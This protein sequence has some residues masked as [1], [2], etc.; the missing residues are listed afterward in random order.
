MMLR[1][2]NRWLAG[3]AVLSLCTLSLAPSTIRAADTKK[4]DVKWET[5]SDKVPENLEEL[6]ALQDRVKKVVDK[7]S[8][9][10]VGILIGFGAGSAVIVSEDGLVLTAAHVVT[11]E[12]PNGKTTPY[13]P[14]KECRIVLSDGKRVKAKSLGV[15]SDTDCGMV[16]ITEKNPKEGSDGKWPFLPIGKSADVKKGQ[17]VVS[18]G[19]PGGPKPGR[20]P[21]AR[22]GRVEGSTKE[23]LRSNCT[24]VGGDS[25]GPLFDLDGNVIGIHS[26]IGLTL[27]HN[28]HI[29][30]EAFKAQWDKLYSSKVFGKVKRPAPLVGLVFS[31][32]DGDDA[33]VADVPDDSPAGKAG[34]KAG[35]TITKVD[36]RSIKS[37]E[38]F[39]EAIQDH[40]PG[41]NVK[42]TVRR[43]TEVL[44]L[45]VTLG[46]KP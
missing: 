9:S 21:V 4:I 7:C 32:D 43:G 46:K 37:V 24:L 19:H 45:T 11:G 34:L 8:A 27:A 23:L 33:W 40:K 41:E 39:R 15:N 10:T 38:A 26:R 3:V 44:T 30:T 1:W 42:F 35:D 12:D 20:P 2:S 17:W 31:D 18:L 13:D 14:G 22:L 5:A 36:R 28:I 25:G 29:A 6:A 16:Q